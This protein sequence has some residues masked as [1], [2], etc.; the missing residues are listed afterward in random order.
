MTKVHPTLCP[1]SHQNDFSPTFQVENPLTVLFYVI[2]HK[3]L[4]CQNIITSS[5]SPELLHGFARGLAPVAFLRNITLLSINMKANWRANF[6]MSGEQVNQCNN[7][8]SGETMEVRSFD[9][10]IVSSK[11]TCLLKKFP[12]SSFH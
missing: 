1:D 3:I 9:K 5:V 6:L 11:N 2:C 12:L 10:V 4:S 7:N 8:N